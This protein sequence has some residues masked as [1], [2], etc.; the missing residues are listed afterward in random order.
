MLIY[1]KTLLKGVFPKIVPDA[2]AF[3]YP[4]KLI[5]SHKKGKKPIFTVSYSL[6]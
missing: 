2:G 3:A 4:K 5:I 1:E 6:F